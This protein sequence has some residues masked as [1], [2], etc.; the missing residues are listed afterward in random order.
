MGQFNCDPPGGE[1][2]NVGMQ[3]TEGWIYLSELNGYCGAPRGWGGCSR[4]S[5][6]HNCG[7]FLCNDV[8]RPRLAQPSPLCTNKME[9]HANAVYSE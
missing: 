2:G 9:A 3:C 7:I 6:S 1:V 4:V 5:C 8:S